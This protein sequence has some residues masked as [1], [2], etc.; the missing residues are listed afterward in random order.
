MRTEFTRGLAVLNSGESAQG[1]AR[2]VGGA[3]RGGKP[4][5]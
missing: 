4:A 2:F 1:A 3:G 5:D